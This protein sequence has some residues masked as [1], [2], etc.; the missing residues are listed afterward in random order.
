MST[1]VPP[2][3]SP[4][5][6]AT[7]P[8][9]AMAPET[10]AQAALGGRF[11]GRAAFDYQVLHFLQ[12]AAD[13]GWPELVVADPDFAD[14]PWGTAAAMELL[15]RWARQGRQMTVLAYRFDALPRRHPRWVQ[16]RT[17]W[18]HKLQC[19]KLLAR[20]VSRV[21]S[22]LWSP[23]WAVRRLDVERCVGMA[24]AER[25]EIVKL[26]EELQEWVKHQSTPAFPASVLGL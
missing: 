13:E 11:E 1:P 22:A 12:R 16:W 9:S 20:D 7:A 25:P 3:S 5:A 14:W 6:A 2:A 15:N 23:Q 24:S 10:V 19:R 18:D 4:V 8:A 26:G 17:T 21:P